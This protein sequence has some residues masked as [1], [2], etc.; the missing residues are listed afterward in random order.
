MPAIFP[1]YPCEVCGNSHTLYYPGAEAV[2]DLSKPHFYTCPWMPVA[3]QVTAGDRLKP[4]REK[5][6][7]AVEV[8]VKS[9]DADEARNA[10]RSAEGPHFGPIW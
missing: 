1:S 7:G 9:E 4:M 5:P 6:E 2:P 3:V 10:I 8:L